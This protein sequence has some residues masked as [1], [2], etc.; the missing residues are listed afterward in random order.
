MSEPSPFIFLATPCYGG[1]VNIYFMRSVLALQG[2]CEARGVGLHLE[3]LDGDAL[4]TRAR[5]RLAARFLAHGQAT[6]MLFVDA[7]IGFAPE[8][9]FRLLDA[10]R[11]IAAGVC[12]LKQI[13]WEKVRVAVRAGAP[14]LM[15]RSVGYVL[16]FI[17]TADNSVEVE[18]GF[19]KVAYAGTGVQLIRR[20]ALERVA[21]A[22]PEL[23][24]DLSDIEPGATAVPML[25]DTL[26]EPATGQHLSED[27]A[28]CRRWRDLGGEIWADVQ[29]RY[30]HVGHAAY[31][32]SL[33]EAM[34]PL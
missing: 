7:D 11:D 1:L 33:L 4:I 21:A 2:A 18:D 20:A 17:P 25:F 10:G 3:L 31:A 34:R 12:P 14:D 22:H 9:V 32:G 23:V 19:A 24:A 26:I 8:N 28:F 5:A 13:D 6:H 29:S 27:Y 15:A 16:R 30:I